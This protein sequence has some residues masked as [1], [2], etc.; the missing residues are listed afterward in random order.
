[1]KSNLTFKFS[2]ECIVLGLIVACFDL[3][4]LCFCSFFILNDEHDN[5]GI[6]VL[7]FFSMGI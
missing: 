1:M 7:F 5:T 6:K 3:T 4:S 2:G